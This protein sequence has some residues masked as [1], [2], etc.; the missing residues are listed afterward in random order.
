MRIMIA[1]ALAALLA[2]CPVL[3]Q[4]PGSVV[5]HG[6]SFNPA[7]PFVTPEAIANGINAALTA[8]AD[9]VAGTQAPERNGATGL[10][11]EASPFV[12][13]DGTA[14]IQ[15]ALTALAAAHGGQLTLSSSR[16]NMIAGATI[17]TPG[18]TLKCGARGFNVDPDGLSP[19][20]TGTKI[21]TPAAAAGFTIGSNSSRVQGIVV[22]DCY[23]RGSGTITDGSTGITINGAGGGLDTPRFNYGSFNNLNTGMNVTGALDT[24]LMLGTIFLGNGTGINISGLGTVFW[25]QFIGLG[26]ADHA[27]WLYNDASGSTGG[28]LIGGLFAR[29][30]YVLTT[31]CANINLT[32]N[33][34]SII[35]AVIDQPG[36]NFL[37]STQVAADGVRIDGEFNRIIGTWNNRTP[38]GNSFHLT[39][40]AKFNL[41]DANLLGAPSGVSFLLD[42]GA[43]GN[44]ITSQAAATITDNSGCD[45]QFDYI[46][47]ATHVRI[48]QNAD[49]PILT[50]RAHA[51]SL[52]GA[53]LTFDATH[54]AGGHSF[55]I[56]A[57]AGSAGEGQGFFCLAD[58]GVDRW[59]I[60]PFGVLNV[61]IAISTP[62]YVVNGTI[63][64]VSG[65]SATTSGIISGSTAGA[66]KAG[67]SGTCTVTVT[68]A[69]VT[70]AHYWVCFASNQTTPANAIV[71]TATSTTGCT[72]T[73]TTV[74]NDTIQ[75]HAIGI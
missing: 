52:Y 53:G 43:C 14:G 44:S 26:M 65:C 71:A 74:T 42:S 39:T 60:N 38:A 47:N 15:S 57:T 68:M 72:F 5:L 61:P 2:V 59:C 31:H 48:I 54:V 21:L 36:L 17:T 25:G 66:F 62:A 22:D 24:P 7:L 32:S 4:T 56:E 8:K 30:C 58:G 35:G 11:T 40:N 55:T 37:A 73:G 41:F 49:Q 18:V 28:N 70:T 46:D 6:P 23:L 67:V 45:N 50:L 13:S 20:I 33:G 63:F 10:G 3:A 1:G 19:G 51:T 64:T 34:G 27:Q 12:S 16:Y 75:W 29:G 9:Y 69:G